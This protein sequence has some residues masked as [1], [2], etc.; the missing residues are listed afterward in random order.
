MDKNSSSRR[1]TSVVEKESARSVA[2]SLNLY[3]R[4]GELIAGKTHLFGR[5]AE[6]HAFGISPI[7][8]DRQRAGHLWDVDGNEYIDFNMGTGAVFLGHAYPSVVKAVQDQAALGTGLTLNHPLEIE[9][10]ELLAEIVPCAE[11]VRFCKGGGESNMVAIRIARAATGR[12]KVVFCGYHGWHDWYISAN[13]GAPT[14]LEKH[15]LPGN[16]PPR[17][18]EPAGRDH[19]SLRVQQSRLTQ[20]SP[21]SEPG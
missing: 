7:Y 8:S 17:R 6:L 1:S 10:A 14:A 13:L 11:M 21:G 16:N 5:R 15:L 19:F 3:R 12:D 18:S 9:T 2:G 4:A 20:E